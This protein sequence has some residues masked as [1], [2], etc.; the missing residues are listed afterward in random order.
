M[1]DISIKGAISS[2]FGVSRPVFTGVDNTVN[3]E[4]EKDVI[5][6]EDNKDP[7]EK[8]EQVSLLQENDKSLQSLSERSKDK[9][10]ESK[11]I[12]KVLQERN[13]K[14]AQE[15]MYALNQ[16]NIGLSFSFD[17]SENTLV[18][19]TDMNT[20][21]LVRQIPSEEF[22]EFAEKLDKMIEENQSSLSLDKD[23]VKGLLLDDKV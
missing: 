8:I 21:K 5:K 17:D 22:L 20:K 19:V 10:A 11:E 2:L 7:K 3:N 1:S 23:E 6:A 14:L 15:R 12:S 16:Q 18:R 13:E 4:E 9:A